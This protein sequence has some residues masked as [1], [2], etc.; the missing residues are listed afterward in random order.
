MSGLLRLGV[1]S[2]VF[3]AFVIAA[4]IARSPTVLLLGLLAF[5]ATDVAMRLFGRSDRERGWPRNETAMGSWENSARH[6]VRTSVTLF[7]ATAVGGFLIEYE[8]GSRNVW[9]A[10]MLGL[11]CASI[12]TYKSV[13]TMREIRRNATDDSSS[14]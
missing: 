12:L 10:V 11:V 3:L 13:G 1:M 4:L 9:L 7:I 5:I 6:I 8:A 2:A 14:N